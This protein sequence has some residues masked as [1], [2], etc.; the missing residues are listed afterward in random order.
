M[1]VG[2]WEGDLEDAFYEGGELVQGLREGR[3]EGEI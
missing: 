3:R 2:G 1:G